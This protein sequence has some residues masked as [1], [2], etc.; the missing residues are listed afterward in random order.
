MVFFVDVIVVVVGGGGVDDVVAVAVVVGS[1][2]P[3]TLKKNR[4]PNLEMTWNGRMEKLK[5]HQKDRQGTSYH[6]ASQIWHKIA[7]LTD[8]W[9]DGTDELMERSVYC[10]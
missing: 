10:I 9:I 4:F 6:K 3:S 5:G 7:Q 1:N 2:L 8:R